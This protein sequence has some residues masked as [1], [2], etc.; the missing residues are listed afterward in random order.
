METI[1][2][3]IKLLSKNEL[4]LDVTEAGKIIK[5]LITT[6]DLIDL[7]QDLDGAV[8]AA[9]IMSAIDKF[10]G[11][12]KGS[13]ADPAIAARFEALFGAIEDESEYISLDPVSLPDWVLS[14]VVS[15]LSEGRAA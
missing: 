13:N 9:P 6:Q 7:D 15:R 8:P 11:Y 1:E 12:L 4:I 2:I 14:E 5:A 3:R 10:R